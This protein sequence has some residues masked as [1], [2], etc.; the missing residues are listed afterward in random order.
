MAEP[1][2]G[3]LN[4]VAPQYDNTASAAKA[5]RKKHDETPNST[6]SLFSNRPLIFQHIH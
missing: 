5:G 4:N 2:L 6:N 1:V 3:Q